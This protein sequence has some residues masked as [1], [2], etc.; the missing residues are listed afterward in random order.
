[1]GELVR[2]VAPGGR[3]IVVTWCHRNLLPNEKSLTDSE[4]ALLK[5]ICDAYYLPAWCSTDDYVKIAKDLGLEDIQTADW[6]EFIAPFWPAV[7]E[8]AISVQ[9]LVGLLRS[10]LKTIR[11]ALVMRLMVE[12][13]KKG[14][15]K[16]ALITCRKPCSQV[17]SNG[18]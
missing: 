15:I 5:R 7:I 17:V 2:V 8:S 14:L 11:G 3:I 1:M 4:Q 6:T 9:G 18:A 10:G 16:F 12:G 13:Y